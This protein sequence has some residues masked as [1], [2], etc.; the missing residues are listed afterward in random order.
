MINSSMQPTSSKMK[1]GLLSLFI[2]FLA[3]GN[4][5]AQEKIYYNQTEFGANF[6]KEVDDWN[7][8]SDS[9]VNFSMTTFH[10]VRF[11][12]HHVGG[13]SLGFDRYETI[14]VVPA[15]FGWKG[16][17]G[18]QTKAKLVTGF[19]LGVGMMFLEK[20]EKNEWGANWYE[21]GLFLS[22]SVGGYFPGKKGKTALTLT[23]AY[24][25]QGFSLFNGTY[26]Q[27]TTRPRPG[28]IASATLPDGFSSVT[29][30]NFLF[31]SLVA[32]I[33]LSF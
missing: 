8:K 7:G 20:T 32:R 33:G 12:K 13:I 23:V 24:K 29:E 1:I 15:A 14:S 16:L 27:S 2:Y 22:P 18:E 10:G 6:G 26:D 31:N 4:S 28:S 21:N 3:V 25:R 11:G 19:D 9:R 17:F 30:T 5:Y